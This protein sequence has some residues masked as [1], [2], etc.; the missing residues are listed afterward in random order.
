M[1]M[2]LGNVAT[3][4]FQGIVTSADPIYILE[5]LG[6][7]AVGYKVH[8]KF[9]GEDIEI[10][11]NFV[12]PFLKNYTIEP[13]VQPQYK[14]VLLFPYNPVGLVDWP[15]IEDQTPLTAS[16]LRQA[17]PFLLAGSMGNWT[18]NVGMGTSI[19]RTSTILETRN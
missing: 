14:H 3:N 19:Q 1:P 8:S 12:E 9:L 17:E 4:I 11:R 13:Y 15:V 2:K 10:E 6:V 5:I 16:Y 18:T 7:T